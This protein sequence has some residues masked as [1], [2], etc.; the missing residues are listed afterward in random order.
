MLELKFGLGPLVYIL[1]LGLINLGLFI[2]FCQVVFIVHGLGMLK[3]EHVD[4]DC[5]SQ[6]W[7]S[8]FNL[9]SLFLQFVW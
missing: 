3:Y 4:L 6:K 2:E 9:F 8:G 5:F 1:H 7:V